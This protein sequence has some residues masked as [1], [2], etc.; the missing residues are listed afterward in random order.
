MVIHNR[1]GLNQ[2]HCIEVVPPRDST[3]AYVLV[4]DSAFG[5]ASALDTFTTSGYYHITT[6]SAQRLQNGNTLCVESDNG[7]V[8]EWDTTGTIVWQYNAGATP[9]AFKYARPIIPASLPCS[10]RR[11][12]R[13]FRCHEPP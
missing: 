9:S 11:R 10:A 8:R 2:T 3:G 13:I 12:L 1:E 6:G 7:M 4:P 5:P